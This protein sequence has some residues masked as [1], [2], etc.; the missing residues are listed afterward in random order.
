MQIAENIRLLRVSRGLTEGEA[1]KL[2]GVGRTTYQNWENNTEPDI[3]RIK[4]IADVFGVHYVQV[5]DGQDA[6]I[7]DPTIKDEDVY[8]TIKR[9]ELAKF[10]INL[11][12]LDLI[13]SDALG[14][15]KGTHKGI[16]DVAL[17]DKRKPHQAVKKK[18]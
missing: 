8:V 1:A 10:K 17:E 11:D 7:P 14:L 2:L 9:S 3:A 16:A 12:A 15:G 6:E 4:Q 5:I 18:R 13:F